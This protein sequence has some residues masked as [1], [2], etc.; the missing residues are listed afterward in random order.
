MNFLYSLETPFQA[1]TFSTHLNFATLS[2]HVWLFVFVVYSRKKM[3]DYVLFLEQGN[4]EAQEM[5]R[6][7]NLGIGLVLIISPQQQTDVLQ[8]LTD[9]GETVKCIGVVTKYLEGKNRPL[10]SR[11]VLT[12]RGFVCELI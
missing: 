9:L 11:F 12:I 10:V 8:Q 2:S 1:S 7:F 6:T 5:A 3:F 4:V